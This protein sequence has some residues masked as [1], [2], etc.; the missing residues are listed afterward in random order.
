MKNRAYEYGKA[1]L[2]RWA[3]GWTCSPAGN[4]QRETRAP[5]ALRPLN[6]W[7]SPR[8]ERSSGLF[9][10]TG[11]RGS[12]AFRGRPLALRRSRW[13]SVPISCAPPGIAGVISMLPTKLSRL[14]LPRDE[15]TGQRR[16]AR[17]P[18]SAFSRKRSSPIKRLLGK[19]PG[20]STGG[21]CE[22]SS[23][24]E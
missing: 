11:A 17:F 8:E 24:T 2:M 23:K 3:L 18:V 7:G 9:H 10:V 15:G 1:V 19:Q 21:K 5:A 16:W 12:C 4:T 22:F 13:V 20:G 14:L 6:G